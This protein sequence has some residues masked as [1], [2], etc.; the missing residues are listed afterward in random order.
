MNVKK[1]EIFRAVALVLLL[2]APVVCLA[3]KCI[4]GLVCSVSAFIAGRIGGECAS[5]EVPPWFKP[6]TVNKTT[7]SKHL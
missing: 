3:G 2:F 1:S 4:T 6:S 7:T 5:E